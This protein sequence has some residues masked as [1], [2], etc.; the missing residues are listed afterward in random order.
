MVKIFHYKYEYGAR[1]KL[2]TFRKN[3]M[4]MK[5]IEKHKSTECTDKKL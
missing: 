2:Y 1:I 5:E 4:K 3:T